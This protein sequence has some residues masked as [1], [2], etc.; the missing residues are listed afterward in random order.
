[1]FKSVV[2]ALTAA[3]MVTCVGCNSVKNEAAVQPSVQPPQKPAFFSCKFVEGGWSEADWTFVKSPRF[4][5]K[6]NK[7]KQEAD[8]IRN[9]VPEGLTD[10]QLLAC[11]ECY[12][13]MV[14]KDMLNGKAEISATTSFDYRMA[15]EIVI[16]APLEADKDGFPQYAE[17]WEIVLF[18][19]GIN[20]WHHEIRDGK[21]FWRKAAF[22]NTRFEPKKQYTMTAK[23]DFTAKC[24][25]L[26]VTCNDTK[27]G[28]M[29]PTLPKDYYVGINACEGIN[30]FYDFS[31]RK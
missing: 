22:V 19:E 17:H 29:L 12:T 10:K 21:P 7:W 16:S 24:P 20:V 23:I 18:D 5:F 11:N 27:F 3:V 31:I 8:C 2:C 15:P 6:N 28:C 1:M 30:R 26:T 13:S 25:I 4:V 14:Y 9:I